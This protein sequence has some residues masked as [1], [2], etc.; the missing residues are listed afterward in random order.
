MPPLVFGDIGIDHLGVECLFVVAV[1]HDQVAVEQ[2]AGD[3]EFHLRTVGRSAVEDQAGAG[4]RAERYADISA[5][6]PIVDDLIEL[7]AGL[8]LWSYSRV[9]TINEKLLADTAARFLASRVSIIDGVYLV[10]NQR[11]F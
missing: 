11:G 2:Q 5:A 8:N 7:D 1:I 4:Q 3:T 6:E 10:R 9:D